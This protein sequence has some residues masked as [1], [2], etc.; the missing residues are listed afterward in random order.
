MKCTSVASRVHGTTGDAVLER[1]V[2]AEDDVQH[3]LRRLGRE[4]GERLDGLA[5]AV[6]AER[7]LAQELALRR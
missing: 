6:V 5:H 3:G 7:D 2:V 1:P 4:A